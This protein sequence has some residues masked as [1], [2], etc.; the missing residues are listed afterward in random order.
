MRGLVLSQWYMRLKDLMA[1]QDTGSLLVSAAAADFVHGAV[2]L[3]THADDWVRPWRF[4]LE[5]LRSLG[6]CLAW[7]PGLFRQM[8]RTTAGISL[9]FET[10][11]SL[12][13]LE[14]KLDDEPTGTRS[15][16]NHVQDEG[17]TAAH[18]GISADVDGCHQS[19]CLPSND[20]DFVSFVLD[21]PQTAT[22]DAL[23]HLPGMGSTHHVRLWLPCL[24][25]C[26]IRTI[27]GNGSFIE[28]VEKRRQLLVLGD[29]IAQGFVCEDPGL[30]WPSRVADRFGLDVINQGIGGQVCQPGTLFGLASSIDPQIIVVELGENYRYEPCR[31]RPVTRDIRAYLLELSRIWP[32]V[33]TFVLTPL[34]HNEKNYPSHPM[35]CFAQVPTFLLAHTAPHDQMILVDGHRLMDARSSLLADGYEHPGPLGSEQI[36]TRLGNVIYA[37]TT[38][39]AALKD[40]ALAALK[41]APLRT[42]VLSE[43]IARN[44]GTVVFSSDA[45]VLVRL[46]DGTQL[47]WAQDQQSATDCIS[48]LMEDELVICVEP[49]VVRE[50]A[51]RT[52]LSCITPF[53]ICI[54][55]KKTPVNVSSDF[56]I[57][58]L[59]ESYFELVRTQY[60]YPAYLSDFYLR[61]QLR[62]GAF[63]GG[64][65]DGQLVGFIGEHPCGSL[66][67]L[68]IFEPYRRR[69]WGFALEGTKINQQLE[70]GFMP[71]CEVYPENA[72]SLS[73]QQKLGL[74][75]IAANEQ[76]Y[77]SRPCPEDALG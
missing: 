62:A 41:D 56:D 14:L 22:H 7:H 66:G 57:R 64:F 31:P 53:Q 68:Q 28:P 45:C 74:H 72:V 2:R 27:V 37:H 30:N 55:T 32:N 19:V 16:L 77:L 35:S 13:A 1:A 47:F 40:Q 18:D 58:T 25:G 63:L 42:Q 5:Q 20:D 59:D 48:A 15:V 54:Y 8:A 52:Q 34:W 4:S 51:S 10:D 9:E 29:S 38:T 76:C 21:N 24:R 69:G 43:V 65:E 75:V 50:V 39:Q 60:E 46:D 73:L 11:A 3:E 70:K 6:S 12:I 49:R 61:A 23:V 36:A 26:Q 33:A 67:L 44:L 71:W 17:T